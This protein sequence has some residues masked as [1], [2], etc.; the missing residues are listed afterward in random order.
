MSALALVDELLDNFG[1]TYGY[2]TWQEMK[3]ISKRK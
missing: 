1:D 3:K 2:A